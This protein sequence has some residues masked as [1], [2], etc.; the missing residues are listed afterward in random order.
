VFG[1]AEAGYYTL[2]VGPSGD[3]Y[4]GLLAVAAGLVLV[5]SG[6]ATLW[7]S[8]RLDDRRLRRYPRR[9]LIAAAAAVALWALGLP[10]ALAYATTHA[11]Q[12]IVPAAELGAAYEDVAFTTSDGLRLAGWYV[13]SRNGA[14]VIV[15]P[16]R[17]GPQARA[18]FLA[19]HGY[20]VLLFDRRGE[21]ESEGDGNMFGWGGEKDILAAIAFLKA[22]PDVDPTRIAGLGL[23]VGAE[24]MLQTAA[25]TGD[26]AAVV[27]DGAGTRSFGEEMEEFHG[28][29]KWLGLPLLA[30]KTASLAIFS[31]TA[32]PPK[33]TD[34]VP[35]IR[36][37]LFLIWSIDGGVETMNPTYFRLAGGPKAIWG[38]PG[39]DHLGALEA[40]P[41]E[42]ERRVIDFL[43]RALLGRPAR[44]R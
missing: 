29:S 9:A 33:L 30:M 7:R 14:A 37:P 44:P 25:G 6:A 19:R 13:P 24:L 10:I 34:L 38:V 1:I 40:H 36:T 3:D 4:T 28:P 12:P 26:L 31:N 18:R 27:S 17:R 42:Y 41:K 32:P 22:R 39:V 20:G 43:D 35:R 11:M 23:S 21:G 8:R 2:R 15:F 5:G 16:G